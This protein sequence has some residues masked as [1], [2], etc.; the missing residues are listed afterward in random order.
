MTRILVLLSLAGLL[1]TADVPTALAED[2]T[3]KDYV[4]YVRPFV[5]SW[6]LTIDREGNSVE[7]TYRARI[8][9]SS[10]CVIGRIAAPGVGSFQSIDGYDPVANQWTVVGF[11]ADGGFMMSRGTLH[12]VRKG[13][14]YAKGH[15]QTGQMT[16]HQPDGTVAT[17]TSKNTCDELSENRMVFVQSEAKM[18]GEPA[19]GEEWTFE[20][21]PEE[22]RRR[23]APTESQ[24]ADSVEL[25]AKDYITYLK[26][27]QGSWKTTAESGGKTLEG[28]ASLRMSP[29]GTCFL[30]QD[31]GAG[32]PPS[33]SIHGYDPVSKRWTVAGFD[34]D[35]GFALSRFEF[36]GVQKDQV[37]GQGVKASCVDEYFRKDGTTTTTTST[38]ACVECTENRIAYVLSD[39]KE[40]GVAKPD[41]TFAMER[42]PNDGKRARQ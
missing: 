22:R 10:T 30:G 37:F 9:R 3:A 35:G 34:A 4:E 16:F 39:R 18:N 26:P 36:I 12:D 25:T 19:P 27:F 32:F 42:Q 28:T 41:L 40:D 24:V 17:L 13:Q 23:P 5:G 11:G 8:A 31:E 14:H 21:L 2:L 1:F 29:V 7:G 6:R 20:R 33:Q 15:S 38:L